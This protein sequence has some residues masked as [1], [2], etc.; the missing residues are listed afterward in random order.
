M[1]RI[2]AEAP[3]HRGDAPGWQTGTRL[4]LPACISSLCFSWDHEPQCTCV[5]ILPHK[6]VPH[7]RAAEG[8]PKNRPP[9]LW[10]ATWEPAPHIP[11]PNRIELCLRRKQGQRWD[12]PASLRVGR[13]GRWVPCPCTTDRPR[14]GTAVS[15]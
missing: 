12:G 5:S 15:C 2:T 14:S 8:S 6:A 13:L 4:G 1:L 3:Q 9:S 7:S 11:D 10:G